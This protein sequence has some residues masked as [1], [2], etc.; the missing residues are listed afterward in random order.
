MSDAVASDIFECLYGY[1]YLKR[2]YEIIPVLADGMPKA[3]ED[4][5]TYKIRIKKG[6]YFHDNACF[7]GGK[8]RELKASDFVFAWKRIADIKTLSRHWWV[9]NSRIVGLDEFRQYSKTCKRRGDVDYSR[10]VEGLKAI[11]DYTLVIKLKRP[12]PQILYLLAYLPTAPTAK[13]AADY[14]GKDIVNHPVGTGPFQ[15]VVWNRGSYIEAV[16]NPNY[17]EDFYPSHGEEG[18]LEKGLLRDAGKRI[19]FADRI[20]WRV[21]VED[22]PRWLMF[23]KG[24]TDITSIPKDNFGQAVAMGM[25]LTEDMKQR[26]VKLAVFGEPDTFY[27]GMN[28]EDPILGKN[29]FLRLAI[30]C[31]FDRQKWID[32]F[33]NGRGVVA[34][35]FIPPDMPGYDAG[36]VS[37]SRTEYNVEKGRELLKKAEAFA[38]G[39][40]PTLRLTV[41]GNSTRYRQ[42]GQFLEQAMEDIGLDVEVECP[43]WPTFLE[44]LRTKGLQV[45]SVGWIADYPD[46]ESFLQVFY[47]K[48]SPWP[49]SSNYHSEEFDRIYE[50]AAF[51]EDSPQRT[52]LYR[53]AERIVVKDAPV[54][55]LYHRI[56]YAMHH[57]WIENFKANAYKPESCG[58]GLSKYYKVNTAKRSKYRDKYR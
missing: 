25:E 27:V 19:P 21:V 35:G 13:E 15:L 30:S 56:W 55:F 54:A 32:L 7:Q 57:E 34:H 8:G 10:Q 52:A 6:V 41:G 31:A 39:K 4:R 47:S 44:K 43:D 2:P 22:Q 42:M 9:F 17:R 33:F 58:Y 49:N 53:K 38:S 46:V 36:I 11:D 14:Y 37:V 45:Y 50:K 26:R 28:M 1:H 51:M 23:L 3:S 18:D 40:I 24:N 48:N 16:R 12:W 5:L 29:K 20:I